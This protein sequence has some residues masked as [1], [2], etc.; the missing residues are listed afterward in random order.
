[1]ILDA[2]MRRSKTKRGSPHLGAFARRGKFDRAVLRYDPPDTSPAV[3]MMSDELQI[4]EALNLAAPVEGQ[5]NTPAALTEDLV[6]AQLE[7]PAPSLERSNNSGRD[8]A[9]MPAGKVR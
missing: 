5:N 9:A 7:D 3:A 2:C 4:G 6:L 1:M 8:A